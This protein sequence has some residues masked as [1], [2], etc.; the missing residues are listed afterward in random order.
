MSPRPTWQSAL[1]LCV[2]PLAALAPACSDSLPAR[3]DGR[4]K[5]ESPAPQGRP[6]GGV[7]VGGMPG[8]PASILS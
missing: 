2:L 3:A 5:V 6:G 7:H 4:S 1:L 8:C